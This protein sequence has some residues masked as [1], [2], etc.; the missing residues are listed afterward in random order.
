MGWIRLSCFQSKARAKIVSLTPARLKEIIHQA[1]FPLRSRETVFITIWNGVELFR[2]YRSPR[3]CSTRIK[4]GTATTHPEI[5]TKRVKRPLPS[6][7]AKP[8]RYDQTG[9]RTIL[10]SAIC[11]AWIV[12]FHSAPTLNHKKHKDTDFVKFASEILYCEHIGKPHRHLEQYWSTR[13]RFGLVICDGCRQIIAVHPDQEHIRRVCA[14]HF[15][16]ASI[17]LEG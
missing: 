6:H 9:A 8:G 16:V 5:I 12:G 7:N 14:N 15:P 2:E 4:L 17:T 11:R 10:I 1:G 13:L 3:Y